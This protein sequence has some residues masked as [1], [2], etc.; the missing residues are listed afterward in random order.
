[1]QRIIVSVI[2]D[3]DTDQ[4]VKKVCQT[5][6]DMGFEVILIGRVL[7]GSAQLLRPYQTRR[8]KLFFNKGILF[9]AEFNTRLFFEL[10]FGKPDILLS[11]DLDTLLPNYLIYK[12]FKK[13]LVYDSHELFTEIPELKGRPGIKKIWALIESSILP[14]IKNMYTVNRLIAHHYHSKY[15]IPVDVIRNLPYKLD[16]N[17]P[18]KE[19]RERIKQNRKMIILQ[20]MGLNMDRGAEESVLMMKYLENTLLYIIGGGD[21]HGKLADLISDNHLEEKVFLLPKMPYEEL[22]K[23]TCLADLGLSL[24]KNTNLN[25]EW[26]LPNKLFDYVQCHVPVLVSDRKLVAEFV[27]NNNIGFVTKNF[28]PLLLAQTVSSIFADEK[29]YRIWKKNLEKIALE[30]TWENESEKLIKFFNKIV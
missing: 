18:E 2:N 5:L 20:G 25:Y 3:L 17:I 30:Y 26:S 23:Y 15:K 19:F 1:M 16:I 11:N 28:D 24:D 8:L 7:P 14:R 4:R 27:K 13:K 10:L 6:F 29:T 22:I 21:M 9:Y 12:L